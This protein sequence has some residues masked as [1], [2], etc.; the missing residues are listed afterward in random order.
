[1]AIYNEPEGWV[2]HDGI[3]TPFTKQEIVVSPMASHLERV[4][5]LRA[6]VRDRGFSFTPLGEAKADGRPARTLKVA[7][8]GHPDI[9]L[10]FDKE[11]RLVTRCVFKAAWPRARGKM[12]YD[13][14]LRD[15]RELGRESDERL[16]KEAGVDTTGPAL[17]ALLRRQTAD[18]ARLARARELVRRLGDD[19]FEVREK[20]TAGLV[21]L[22]APVQGLIEAASH[23]RDPEVARRAKRC[24]QQLGAQPSPAVVAA[25]RLIALRRPA[26]ATETLLDYLPGA[27]GEV[28]AEVQ[29]ALFQLASHD[30]KPDPA[31]MR[32]LADGDSL[33]RAAAAAALGK[34]GGA[35]GRQPGRRVYPAGRKHYTKTVTYTDGELSG[36]TEILDVRYF[37]A[38]DDK[39]F[40][41]PS[42]GSPAASP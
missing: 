19:S 12:T 29:G 40:A 32:A 18:A 25:V 38:F 26:G 42:A 31:L 28:A 41:R 22:G 34:D 24:L 4:L 9:T 10:Y 37:N 13:T 21:H 36:E 5:E 11:T 35:Y 39:L 27:S 15:Y 30:G 6:L 14:L 23:D 33:R 2:S 7:Y 3:V 20:A 16:L 17:L 1:V 8:K